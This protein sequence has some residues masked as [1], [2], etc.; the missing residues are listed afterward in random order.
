MS[1]AMVLP[2]GGVLRH[3]DARLLKA[4]ARAAGTSMRGRLTL[5]LPSGCTGVIGGAGA[6]G[7]E[8]SLKIVNYAAL[9]DVLRRGLIGFAES[10]LAG[11]LTTPSLNDI[12][13]LYLDN[14]ATLSSALPALE[15]ASRLDRRYHRKRDNTRRGSRRNIAAHYDLGNEFYRL[16][17]YRDMSYSSAIFTQPDMGLEAA[18][19]EKHRRIVDELRVGAGDTVLEIG[20]GWG[21]I[22]EA[23]ARRGADVTAIT[24]SEEQYAAATDRLAKA[25]LSDR[26]RV[27]FQDYRDTVGSFDRIVSIEMI[28]AVGENH[29]PA[30][31]GTLA[32]RLK[33]GGSAVIQAIT[34]RD[35]LMPIYRSRPDFIQRYVFPGGM[36]PS[37]PLMQQHAESAG[38][39]FG[40]IE[41]FGASYA[42]T[43]AEWRHRF[44][45]AWPR[46]EALGFDARF[47]RLWD[48]YLCYCEV[49][50]QRGLIDVGLY[51]FSKPAS[52]PGRGQ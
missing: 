19:A 41:R 31:F 28:E 11:R 36:L 6:S 33:P 29:W 23:V 32:D 42:L 10:Y 38:L 46:I 5:E 25:A 12:F 20:C 18:Q 44:H 2:G 7:I 45:R 50:F 35:D 21:S 48:Y 4:L 9:W 34:L 13:D 30:Y 26:A 39:T 47:R 3:F 16:W 37:V 22:A 1:E 52:V 8:A 24:I 51:R 40:E 43:L 17:F 49:G 15:R 14:E 27:M